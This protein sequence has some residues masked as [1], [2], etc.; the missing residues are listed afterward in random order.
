MNNMAYQH[1][2]FLSLF[3]TR[4]TILSSSDS[5]TFDGFSEFTRP[6]WAE[7]IEASANAISLS[8][9]NFGA[10]DPPHRRPLVSTPKRRSLKN[11]PGLSNDKLHVPL[12]WVSFLT[13]THIRSSHCGPTLVSTS[14]CIYRDGDKRTTYGHMCKKACLNGGSKRRTK[15]APSAAKLV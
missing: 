15:N 6:C 8:T 4:G 10:S 3:R 7:L 13:R 14:V 1:L 12:C 5:Q 11:K 2:K 9:R